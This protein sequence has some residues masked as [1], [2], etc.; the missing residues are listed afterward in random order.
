MAY[1]RA[2][3][4]EM[5]DAYNERMDPQRAADRIARQK[6]VDDV[7]AKLQIRAADAIAR[8]SGDDMAQGRAIFALIQEQDREIRAAEEAAGLRR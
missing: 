7:R 8:L 1:C 6:I 4:Q 3:R 5:R 2:V